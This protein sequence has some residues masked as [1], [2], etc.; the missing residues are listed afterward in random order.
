FLISSEYGTMQAQISGKLKF[1]TESNI[2]YPV[3]GDWVCV[4]YYNNYTL[5]IIHNILTRKTILK[6]KTSGKKIDYQF[7]GANIDT[8]CII[9]S[10]DVDFNVARLERYM[11]AVLD[12]NITPVILLSKCDL[13]GDEERNQTILTVKNR[14]PNHKIIIFS[15]KSYENMDKIKKVFVPRQ[16][17]CIIGSSGVGKTTLLNNLIGSDKFTTKEIRKHE[18]GGKHTTTRRQMITLNNGALFIDTPGMREL[19]II[20]AD[21]GI[22]KVFSDIETITKQCRFPNCSHT[23]ETGCA[24]HKAIQSGQ[25]TQKHFN[26]YAKLLKEQAYHTRSYVE[27]RIKDK[28]FGKMIKSVMNKKNKKQL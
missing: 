22:K 21:S 2:D 24:I 11:V 16:T 9:Q 17:Y 4:E 6:R 10:L 26:N 7:I 18:H 20:S 28:K 27:K 1:K 13:I 3:V 12:A 25:L 19:G 14:Y 23:H 15:N 5:A 8:A